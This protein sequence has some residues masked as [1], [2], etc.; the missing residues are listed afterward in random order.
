MDFDSLLREHKLVDIITV[1]NVHYAIAAQHAVVPGC[2][3]ILVTQL[4]AHLGVFLRQG[5]SQRHR[6]AYSSLANLRQWQLYTYSL[7]ELPTGKKQQFSHALDGSTARPGLVARWSAEKV[8]RGAFLVLK[9][10]EREVLAFLNH[11]QVTYTTCEVL[12]GN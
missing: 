11:W 2:T 6:T 7:A 1:D 10:Y 3:V 8:G 5:Y 9:E 4:G 12:R